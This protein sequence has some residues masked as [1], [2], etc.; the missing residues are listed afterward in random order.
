MDEQGSI[1]EFDVTGALAQISR[2]D[3]GIGD[4]DGLYNAANP[5]Q[6]FGPIDVFPSEGAFTVGS[7]SYDRE[8]VCDSGEVVVAVDSVDLSGL[9][10]AG[11]GT[12]DISDTALGLWFFENEHTSTFGALPDDAASTFTDG[13]LSSIDFTVSVT[14]I[15]DYPPDPTEPEL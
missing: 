14:L 8:Q 11:S 10:Q 2:G 4:A 13:V 12:T 3:G 1:T 6:A 5:E 15:S 9:W 7:L